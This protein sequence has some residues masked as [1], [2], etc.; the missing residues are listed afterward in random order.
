MYGYVTAKL[1]DETVRLSACPQN[2]TDLSLIVRIQEPSNATLSKFNRTGH[3][4]SFL[5][6]LFFTPLYSGRI[7][8]C[9]DIRTRLAEY[10]EEVSIFQIY[11]GSGRVYKVKR[12]NIWSGLAF[13]R[14]AKIK[15][16]ILTARFGSRLLDC[17]EKIGK[18]FKN[19]HESKWSI[20]NTVED[21][22]GRRRRRIS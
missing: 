18:V 5:D 1:E 9:F 11:L 10:G 15:T 7:C 4:I 3:G 12:R 8:E 6:S 2:R 13:T 14:Y 19:P 22:D 21:Y 20:R 16:I 17:G